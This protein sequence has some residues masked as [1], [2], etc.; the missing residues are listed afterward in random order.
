MENKHNPARI[1][2]SKETGMWVVSSDI[3]GKT[4]NK[5]SYGPTTVICP[6][7]GVV[8]QLPLMEAGLLV[9]EINT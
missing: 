2:R 5:I 4:S 6:N 3:A 7:R 9:Y 8:E 1:S